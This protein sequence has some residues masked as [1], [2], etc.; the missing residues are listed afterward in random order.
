MIRKL[1]KY[2]VSAAILATMIQATPTFASPV[3]SPVTLKEINSTK[4]QINDFETKIQQLDN[5]ISLSMEKSQ[6]LNDQ[7]KTQQGKIEKTEAEIENAKKSLDAHKKVYSDRLKSIQLEGKQSIATY[8]ELLLSSDNISEFLTRFTAISH[9]METDTDLLNGLNDK[10]QALE[11]AEEKLHNEFDQLKKSQVELASEQKKIEEDKKEVEKGIAEAKNT[12][13][14]QQAQLAQQKAEQARQLAA[15]QQAQERAQQAQQQSQQP[16]QQAQQQTQQ[17]APVSS[18]PSK[19]APPSV[20]AI[21]TNSGSASAMIAYAKQFLG[22]PYV[23]GGS[24][25]SGFDCSGFTSYVFRSVG[26]NLPRVSRDQQN[27]GTRISPSQVQPG[28][29]VFRGSPAYHVGIYI[30]GGQY[31]H[32]PQTGDVV[33]IA[34]YNPSKFSSAARVLR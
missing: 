2:T 11:N 19:S 26:I 28:D 7:I 8:A 16:A 5:R 20:A 14:N 30:G 25:P 24:T 6:K 32:A 29:L 33:K 10:E 18:R 12:L 22:V 4:V 17:Q 15:Q 3:D 21:S 1:F 31:I 27:V 23:W 9:I 34:S 13:Q